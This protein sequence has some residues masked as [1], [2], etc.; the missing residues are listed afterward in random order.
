MTRESGG[1]AGHGVRW[2][3]SPESAGSHGAA[4]KQASHSHP[5]MP[6]KTQGQF[7]LLL[8]CPV[9]YEAFL[10]SLFGCSLCAN[11]QGLNF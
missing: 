4:T 9:T 6:I 8:I 3:S 2:N 7:P 10:L 5:H 1:E 11:K